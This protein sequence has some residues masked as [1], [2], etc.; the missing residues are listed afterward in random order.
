MGLHVKLIKVG[1]Q[2]MRLVTV[3]LLTLSAGMR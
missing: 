1:P 2:M 3:Y